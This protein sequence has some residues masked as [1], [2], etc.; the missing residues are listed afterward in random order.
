MSCRISNGGRYGALV[1]GIMD[2]KRRNELRAKLRDKIRNSRN[3]DDDTQT[4]AR[5][6]RDDPKTTL[7]G[8][9]IDDAGVLEL[10]PSLV[11]NPHR[12]LGVLAERARAPPPP[13]TSAGSSSKY[14]EENCESIPDKKACHAPTV[15]T[16]K[17]LSDDEGDE[18]LPPDDKEGVMMPNEESDTSDDEGVPPDDDDPPS[19]TTEWRLSTGSD[20]DTGS[21]ANSFIDAKAAMDDAYLAIDAETMNASPTYDSMERVID[22]LAPS[23]C[24]FVHAGPATA[25]W[26]HVVDARCNEVTL[27]G[28][29]TEAA[30]VDLDGLIIARLV[31][32]AARARLD[33]VDA[34][35]TYAVVDDERIGKEEALRYLPKDLTH[36]ASVRLQPNGFRLIDRVEVER[37]SGDKI[38]MKITKRMPA[39]NE[40]NSA[41]RKG[42]RR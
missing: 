3:S 24:G 16:E 38:T 22:K 13:S 34:T 36:L 30:F 8:M 41:R 26:L 28:V 6:M 4:L 29:E 33:T 37:R 21:Q 25:R 40:N 10:A 32:S 5:R 27:S 7:L 42:T 15:S 14:D 11:A 19:T 9:G 17:H 20:H 12:A 18:G 39:R 23:K 1:C 31:G 2:V 35:A